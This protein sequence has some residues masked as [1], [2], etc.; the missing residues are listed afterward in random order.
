M[1]KNQAKDEYLSGNRLYGD[2]FTPAQI[3]EWFEDEREAYFDLEQSGVFAEKYAYGY[4]ARNRK[5]G[6]RHLPER[7][8]PDVLGVGSAYGDE[9]L[10]ILGRC[11][12]VT[13]L[14][15]ADGFQNEHF[16]YVK[17]S[18]GGRFPFS[19]E[20][21]DLITCLSVLHHIPNVSFIIS[22]IAR[23]LRGGGYA[24][25]TEPTHSMGD[26]TYPR[27]GLTK[28]ERGIPVPLL[29]RMVSE[30]GLSI[31]RETKCHFSLTSRLIYITRDCPFNHGWAVNLDDWL[32]RLPI[33]PTSYH[34][35]TWLH[36]IK[37]CALFFVL[38]KN[39]ETNPF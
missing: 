37:P 33:W 3:A 10:P 32:C 9:F 23:V 36:K 2:D 13:I 27:R 11:G 24:L 19:D 25:L 21:F 22:E 28:R 30:S 35:P 16:T 20:S 4:H 1:Q 8:F 7:M 31:V 5:H 12:N 39:Q 34:P 15:P 14:E 26:W 29:R 6:F 17:P 38:T 18:A